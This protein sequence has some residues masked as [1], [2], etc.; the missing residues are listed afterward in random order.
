[1]RNFL[2]E[3]GGFTMCTKP[4]RKAAFTNSFIRLATLALRT[5][6]IKTV[7]SSSRC[8]RH[9]YINVLTSINMHVLADRSYVRSSIA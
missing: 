1:V 7:A 3:A 6:A 9:N 8:H 5:F 4:L 2:R